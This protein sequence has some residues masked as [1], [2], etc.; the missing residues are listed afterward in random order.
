M[1]PHVDPMLFNSVHFLAFFPVAVIVHFLLRDRYRWMWLLAT[2]Y[3]FYMSWR[4]PYVLVLMALTLI[5][6]VA[7]IRIADA[8]T[9]RGKRLF[10]VVSIA[11]N[12]TLLGVFKYFDFFNDSIG[13]LLGLASVRY[14]PPEFDLL[15]P[16]GISFH[17]FQA[18]SY[19][20]DVFKGHKE[21]ERNLGYFALYVAFFP[22]LVA[23][24]IERA[25]HLL[26][27]FRRR[28]D[29]NYALATDG[30]RLMAWGFFKKLV[31]A[32]RV[33]LYVNEVY[34]RPDAHSSLQLAV[35]TYL[36]AYQIYC[37]FSGYSDIAIGAAKVLGYD[38]TRNFAFPYSAM[39]I[40]DFWRRWHIS[41]SSWFRDYVYVPL[42][43]NRGG[44]W[45]TY[46]NVLVV[47]TLSGLWHGANWTF[48]VWG[49]LHG[50]FLVAERATEGFRQRAS[51]FVGFASA[52]RLRAAVSVVVT[53]HLV[54]VAWIFFRAASVGDALTIL[55]RIASL[56][57]T[58]VVVE[59]FGAS[60]LYTALVAIVA[61]EAVQYAQRRTSLNRLIR[62]QPLW[63]RWSVY[64]A[65]VVVILLFGRFDEREFIYF[66][67]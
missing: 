54:V 25:G 29:F 39:G 26:P 15:L 40:G 17:T 1:G 6:Y 7:A 28:H 43:G 58:G 66:Q 55:R 32:D 62:R 64:H 23:G 3:Y 5:D 27:Q 42:G 37:D 63:L 50:A 60:E 53:F 51:S 18:M 8:K 12:L 14:N 19:T 46:R 47:F 2:S 52:P 56:T 13:T 45:K 38:L 41:L 61:L 16:V 65:V 10:L 4:P 34:A 30:L 44:A 20:I 35:A 11:A 49:A 33:A 48:V 24:P 22:Q 36:F 31:I 9:L 21:P 59:G 67:F 57:G